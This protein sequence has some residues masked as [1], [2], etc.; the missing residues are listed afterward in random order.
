MPSKEGYV[1]V[2]NDAEDTMYGNRSGLEGGRGTGDR[3]VP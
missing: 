3:G 2:I 1:W